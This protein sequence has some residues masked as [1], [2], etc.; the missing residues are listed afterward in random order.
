[1]K[2]IF[3]IISIFIG[4]QAFAQCDLTPVPSGAWSV[5]FVDSEWSVDFLGDFAIDGDPASIWHTGQNIPYPHEIQIDLGANYPVSG[6]GM[7]PRQSPTNAKALDHEIYLSNDGVNW[8]I[9]GG[10]SFDYVD[11]SDIGLKQ[12]TFNAIDARYVRLVGLNGYADDYMGIAELSFYQD[13]VCSPTGQNNQLISFDAIP[14]KATDSDP[15][16]LVASSNSGL[17]VTFAIVSGPATVSGNTLTLTGAPGI[18]EVRASQAGDGSYYPTERIRSFEVLD[19]A[20]FFPDATTRLVDTYPLEMPNLT[21]YAIYV[22]SSIDIP[23]GL[24][25]I[26][27]VDVEVGGQTYTATEGGGFYYY[28]WTPDS[29]GTHTVDIKAIA[30][31]G[32]VT[33]VTRNVEV[34]NTVSSQTVASLEDVVIEFGGANSRW[35]YG[36]YTLPQS[37]GAYNNIN[38]SLIVECPSISGGCDD[39]DRWAH[40]DVKG[41]D[42]NWIQVIRYIT[43]YGVACDHELDVTDYMSLLQGEVEFRVF[44]DTWGTG[45]WQLSLNFDYNQ[46]TPDYL[47]SKVVEVWDGSYSFGD[48]ANLQPVEAYTAELLSPLSSSHLRISNTGH[49]WGG[50][51]T[52]NAAEFFNA[53]HFID[54]NAVETFTQHLWNDCNPNPD[55]CTGQQGTWQYSRAGWCPGAISVPDTYDLT[56]YI[57]SNFDLDY[58]FH[59]SYQ[60]NCHPNNPNCVSGMTCADCN[61]GYNPVYFVDTH[62]INRGHLPMAYGDYLGVESFDNIDNFDLVVYPNPAKGFFQLATSNFDGQTRVTVHT[63]DGLN[64]KAYYFDSSTELN[65]YTFNLSGLSSGVYFINLEYGTGT[66]VAR[67]VLE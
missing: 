4:L 1:M 7:L 8:V 49:G 65:N 66:G 29:Y 53:T 62:L 60:D 45:G 37:V 55:G 38:A 14:F 23:D 10:G 39:W 51:N 21:P 3:S 63:I 47:Y 31:N 13:L 35:Y 46:G 42:G 2:N 50:N 43:P 20:L 27:Q 12:S 32:N 22:A 44:I 11:N 64:V 56:P 58:R 36:S 67:I 40:I 9:Q 15:F 26:Q 48:P 33:T 16:D 6:I 59:P 61:D 25:E 52:G 17:A 34:T 19:L 30:T 54:V 41:P 24:A 5:T 57:G 28:M 18:V